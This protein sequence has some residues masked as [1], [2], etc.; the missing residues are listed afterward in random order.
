MIKIGCMYPH[1][2]YLYDSIFRIIP[3]E[4]GYYITKTEA[5]V[6]LSEYLNSLSPEEFANHTAERML[7]HENHSWGV[8]TRWR[9]LF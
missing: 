2:Y 6:A 9:F 3:P 1:R 5:E 8:E 7:A 4:C